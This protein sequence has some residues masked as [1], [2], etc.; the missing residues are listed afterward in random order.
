MGSL[1]GIIKYF[2]DGVLLK[3]KRLDFLQFFDINL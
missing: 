1:Y 2:F 3:T